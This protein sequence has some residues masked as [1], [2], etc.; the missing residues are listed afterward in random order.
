MDVDTV[1]R[2][3]RLLSGSIRLVNPLAGDALHCRIICVPFSQSPPNDMSLVPYDGLSYTWG[4]DTKPRHIIYNNSQIDI[5]Q[6]LFE[7]LHQF[8]KQDRDRSMWVDALCINRSDDEEKFS[9]IPL[10][11]HIYARATCVMIWLGLLDEFTEDALSLVDR[12]AGLLRKETGRYIPLE[13]EMRL[14]SQMPTRMKRG[15]S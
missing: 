9:Q 14:E 8:R 6:N 7:A 1:Y 12:A 15:A 2:Y 13:S 5:T 10:M 4:G 3:N 11:K